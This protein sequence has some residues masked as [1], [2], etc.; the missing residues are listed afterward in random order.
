MKSGRLAFCLLCFPGFG[1]R[2]F[3]GDDEDGHHRQ[4]QYKYRK[5]QKY[6]GGD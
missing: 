3:G 6:S 5:S 4:V 2:V 1:F